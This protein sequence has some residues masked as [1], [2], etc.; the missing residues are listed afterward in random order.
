MPGL[1]AGCRTVVALAVSLACSACGTVSGVSNMLG[2]GSGPQPGQAGYVR[3]FLGGV[4]ADEPHA[5]LAGRQVLSRGGDAAD[6]AVAVALNLAVTLPSRAGLGGGGACLAFAA[7]AGSINA[8]VPEAV[9]FVPSA[10][11]QAGPNADRPAALPMLARGMYLLHA[12]Y[13]KLPFETL[14][15]SA[16]EAARFGVPVSRALE[17]DLTPVSGPLLADPG[18]RAVFSRNGAPLAEG[19]TLAQPALATTLAELRVAGVGDFYQ[20]V[21]ARRLAE[22]SPLAGGPL[23]V[24]ALRDA[25]PKLAPPLTVRAGNDQVAFLPPP[26]DGGLAAAAAFE[27]LL[28]NPNDP[29]GAA[30]RGLAVAARW[31]AGGVTAESLLHAAGLAQAG[32][33]PLPAST[34]FATLDRDGNA[35]VCDLTMNNLFGTGRM[36]PGMGFLL[37]ASPAS[38]PPPL[39]AAAL[40]WNANTHAFRAEIGGSGQAGAPMAVAVG[41]LNAL[42]S[43]RPMAAPV[44]EP[45]RAN[46]IACSRYLPGD[47]GTCAWASDPREAGLATGGG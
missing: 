23:T 42:H 29:A 26:A 28:R 3:G 37:A 33:P 15:V 6:A 36:V 17:R 31:R 30:A 11:P 10:P 7:K 2:S 21:L 34:S 39:L 4:V 44:P 38:G 14:V 16:E 12:R 45:G 8:G 25:L 22:N 35:V 5:A 20:G 13:G 19:Q 9:L 46:A 47:N 43:G 32:L 18:A 24:A 1:V 40:A 41:M 27:S